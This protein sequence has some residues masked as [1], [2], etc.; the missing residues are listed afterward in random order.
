MKQHTGWSQGG[1]PASLPLPHGARGHPLWHSGVH[2]NQE[3][4][5]S[6]LCRVIIGLSSAWR[7]PAQRLLLQVTKSSGFVSYLSS[8]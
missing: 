2:P 7:E 4:L 1:C 5:L 3:A 6:F 8:S